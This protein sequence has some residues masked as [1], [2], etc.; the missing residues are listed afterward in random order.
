MQLSIFFLVPRKATYGNSRFLFALLRFA[1]D[2]RFGFPFRFLSRRFIDLLL[3][4]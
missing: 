1:R 3:S 2:S 4:K